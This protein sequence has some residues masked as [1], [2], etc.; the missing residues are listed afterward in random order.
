[1]YKIKS[2]RSFPNPHVRLGIQF[3]AV[4]IEDGYQLL[5]HLDNFEGKVDGREL[6]VR[7]YIPKLVVIRM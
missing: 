1:M 4:E 7:Q 6:S 2:P 5:C 3:L